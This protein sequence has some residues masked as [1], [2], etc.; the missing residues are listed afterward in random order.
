MK[1]YITPVI[2][3]EN[4]LLGTGLMSSEDLCLLGYNAVQSDKNKPTFQRKK[5][6]HLQG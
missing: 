6:R 4:W 1:V 5:Y 2:S 3:C